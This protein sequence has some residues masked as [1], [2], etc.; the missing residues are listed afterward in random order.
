MTDDHSILANPQRLT[1]I[2]IRAFASAIDAAIRENDLLGVPSYGSEGGK[3]VVRQARLLCL[4]FEASGGDPPGYP[5]ELAV[6]DVTTGEVWESLIA[7]TPAWLETG[8]WE[9]A[10]TAIHGLAR[11]ELIAH[12]RS[13]GEVAAELTA[14]THGAQ[15]L[16]D[17]PTYDTKWLRDLYHATG[18]EPPFQLLDFHQI[19]WRAALLRGRRPDIAIVKAEAEAYLLFPRQH[20]AGPDARRN[21]EMLRQIHG[22]LPL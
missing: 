16:S 4:D 21:A 17:A 12:G 14:R 1:E 10:A 19:A 8:V 15:V 11:A 2:A 13:A 6:A 7:P 9:L 3:I 18:A 5:I 22:L 20:R